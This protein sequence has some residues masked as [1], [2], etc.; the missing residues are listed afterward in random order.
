M[1][2]VWQTTEIIG[3]RVT[4]VMLFDRLPQN[5]QYIVACTEVLPWHKIQSRIADDSTLLLAVVWN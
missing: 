5:I 2:T 3:A 4:I 1:E